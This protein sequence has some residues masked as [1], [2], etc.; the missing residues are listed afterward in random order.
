MSSE[1]ESSSSILLAPLELFS[2]RPPPQLEQLG[3]VFD[4]LFRNSNLKEKSKLAL[5]FKGKKCEFGAL[6]ERVQALA[7]EMLASSEFRSI[8]GGLVWVLATFKTLGILKILQMESWLP[9]LT[10]NSRDGNPLVSLSK[11]FSVHSRSRLF[12]GKM[13]EDGS[14]VVVKVYEREVGS[15]YHGIEFEMSVYERLGRPAPVLPVDGFIL[16]RRVMVMQ[17]L[18]PIDPELD[19]EH[20]IGAAVIRQLFDLHE[21]TVHNDIKPDNIMASRTADGSRVFHLVDFGGCAQDRLPNGMYKRRTWS[22]DWCCQPRV[23]G[24][25]QP[26]CFRQ[27]L[28]ELGD[29]MI[30]IQQ[31]RKPRKTTTGRRLTQYM[32]AVNQL[33][34]E[35]KRPTRKVYDQLISIL[36]S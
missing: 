12:R 26:T 11:A 18:S 36:D 27:D 20:D 29:T 28:I 17:P 25:I 4:Q 21:F 6:K 10:V 32:Q 33:Q 19:D 2:E 3:F 14:N 35:G 9:K 5:G 23:T 34:D 7:F 24:I 1:S 22:R 13:V 30:H 8:D 31:L 15:G 16:G